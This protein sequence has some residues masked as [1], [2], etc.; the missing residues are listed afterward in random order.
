MKNIKNEIKKIIKRYNLIYKN[1]NFDKEKKKVFLYE[2]KL[3]L[4]SFWNNKKKYK[5]FLINLKKK[6]KKIKEYE[7]II[8]YIE[9]LNI[10]LHFCNE[11][12]I[13][14]KEIK[15]YLNKFKKKISY[16]EEK[17]LFLQK[18]DEMNAMIQINAGSGGTDSCDWASIIMRMYLMWAEKKKYKVKKIHC[19]YGEI[20]GIKS[21]ILEIK[22]KYVFGFL[23]GENGIHRLVRISPFD[24]NSKRHTSFVSVYV[25]PLIDDNIKININQSDIYWQT[26]RSGGSGGQHV[27]KVETGVRLYHKKTGIIV[28]NTESRSQIKNKEKALK[29][30]KCKLYE[31]E[32]KKKNEKKN[33]IELKKK[34]NEWGS[35]IRNYIM[36]P[37]KLIKDLRTGME[38]SNVEY[39]LNGNID[40]FLTKYLNKKKIFK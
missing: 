32:I 2:E 8:S 17:N 30:L 29:I 36:H 39:F 27:N 25:Y 26:F 6:K 11:K 24:N 15:Y 13:S 16:I 18:E 10:L 33:E 22:G 40:N 1:F 7:Y 19:T 28:E 23:K 21:I 38:T 31:K 14:E 37:Y 35:Q 5:K 4:S 20:T 3:L 12:T 34:K 9:D